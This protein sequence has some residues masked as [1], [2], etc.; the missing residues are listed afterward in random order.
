[1]GLPDAAWSGPEKYSGFALAARA[2]RLAAKNSFILYKNN[3]IYILGI[4]PSITSFTYH[5]ARVTWKLCIFLLYTLKGKKKLAGEN[6]LKKGPIDNGP[7][8]WY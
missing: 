5:T 1:L 6:G 4:D 8:Q 7:I 2:T 3:K